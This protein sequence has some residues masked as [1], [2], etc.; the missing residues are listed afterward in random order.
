MS[1]A[2]SSKVSCLV[3]AR[4]K[5]QRGLEMGDRQ[6][7]L[8]SKIPEH[9]ARNPAFSKARIEG[10]GTIHQRN[11]GINIPAKK[12]EHKGG[13]AKDVRIVIRDL[14]G[15]AG[16]SEALQPTSFSCP[17]VRHEEVMTLSR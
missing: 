6:I 17:T 5:A 4:V 14:D 1:H 12:S 8:A 13:L 7:R 11:C 16:E 9:A 15:V 3:I 10:E 2:D